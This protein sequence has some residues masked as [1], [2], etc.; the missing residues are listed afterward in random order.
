MSEKKLP[1]KEERMAQ[2]KINAELTDEEMADASGGKFLGGVIPKFKV[3]DHVIVD[4]CPEYDIMIIKAIL[5][6]TE[7]DGWDYEIKA[8]MEGIGWFESIGC[9]SEKYIHHA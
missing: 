1:T 5:W 4:D 9:V 2:L 3:G 8:H 7:E 6:W